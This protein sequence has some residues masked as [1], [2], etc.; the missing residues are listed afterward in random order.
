MLGIISGTVFLKNY[1]IF[2]DFKGIFNNVNEYGEARLMVAEN[3]AFISR[4]GYNQDDYILPHMVNHRA[5]LKAF[6][7][8]GVTE[9]IGINS[10]GSLKI[11]LQPG[12][13]VIPDDF[14]LLSPYPSFLVDKP[15]H[16]TAGLD[17]EMRKKALK[18][19]TA[20][21]IDAKDGGTY[22]QTTGPRLETRAEIRMMSQFADLVGMT[23]ASEAI[24]AQELGLAYASV[25]SIDNYAHGLAGKDE[26]TMEEIAAKARVNG[27]T[28]SRLIVK[29]ITAM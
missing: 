3:I 5:N 11:G 27:E 29:Y 14:I 4:H 10:T 6:Q 17:R 7:E 1:Q 13:I 25:C 16:L 19:A 28:I 21:G 23:M 20:A 12:K 15:V 18:A 8:L 9:I 22:W 2:S 26:L 24:L